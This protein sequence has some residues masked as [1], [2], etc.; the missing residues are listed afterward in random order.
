MSNLYNIL[1]LYA[2]CDFIKPNQC[3]N[4]RERFKQE[5]KAQALLDHPNIVQVTDLFEDNGQ[6]FM[7]MEYVDGQGLDEMITRG[8]LTEKRAL[9]T[10]KDTLAGFNFAHSKGV[11][12]R[13]I[14]PANILIDQNETAK[15]L[16]FGIA[17]LSGKKRLTT[18]GTDV[19]S[20][21][22]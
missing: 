14:K 1:I 7:A 6:F 22:I 20:L 4:F 15:I 10:C 13:D 3:P 12:H 16:D 8:N 9:S 21:G 11:I 19:G 18:T 5:A 2:K 17:L